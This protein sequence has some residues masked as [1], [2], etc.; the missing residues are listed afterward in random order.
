[1][2]SVNNTFHKL[3]PN[4]GVAPGLAVRQKTCDREVPSLTPM[5]VQ[6]TYVCRPMQGR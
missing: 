1:M 5:R 6:S 2:C 4:Q 3:K